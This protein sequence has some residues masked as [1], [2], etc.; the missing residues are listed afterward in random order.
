MVAN[1]DITFKCVNE[2][3]TEVS[4]SNLNE[5]KCIDSSRRYGKARLVSY[6]IHERTEADPTKIRADLLEK[7][8][9]VFKN[10]TPYDS[11][12]QG[13]YNIGGK[14]PAEFLKVQADQLINP[15]GMGRYLV[16]FVYNTEYQAH[17]MRTYK[18]VCE[19]Y[20]QLK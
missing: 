3:G 9:I 6:S 11:Q 14:H 1:F 2:F 16:S 19:A 7:I 18:Q 10:Q 17:V 13:A 15:K 20:Q 12:A 5:I 8:Q 4:T